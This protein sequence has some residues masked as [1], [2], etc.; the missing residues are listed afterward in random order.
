M[1]SFLGYSQ[2]QLPDTLEVCPSASTFN[3]EMNFNSSQSN[4]LTA[5]S[6]ATFTDLSLA[7]DAFSPLIN[8]GFNFNFYGTNYSSCVIS[9]NNFISFNSLNANTASVFTTSVALGTSSPF[10][11][12]NSI[13]APFQD[14]NPQNS[15]N[16]E[17]TTIGTAP[18]R[19][20]VAR[21]YDI[22]MYDCPDL[23]FCSAIIFYESTNIIETHL[24]NKP[25]CED[26]QNGLAIHGLLNSNGTASEVVYDSD[27]M[28]DR[29]F[30][31]LW[32][33]TLEG[34]RFTPSGTNN[35]NVSSINFL[36]IVS[37]ATSQYED[38]L[39]NTYPLQQNTTINNV[40]G[41]T[42]L[43]ASSSVC[44][45]SLRDTT[46]IIDL[47][48]DILIDGNLVNTAA[49][50][51]DEDAIL[52]V[53]NASNFDSFLWSTGET[54]SS[55]TINSTGTYSVTSTKDGCPLS[56]QVTIINHPTYSIDLGI[57]SVICESQT[58]TLNGTTSNT[59][60][61]LWDNGSTNSTRTV[62]TTGDY[63]L[64]GIS[65]QGCEDSDTISITVLPNPEIDLGDDI[66]VCQGVTI[67]IGD[68]I[69]GGNYTWNTGSTSPYIEI[70]SSG[71]YILT[72]RIGN[73]TDIDTIEVNY[74][75][76]PTINL[77]SVAYFCEGDSVT[78]NAFHSPLA[79]YLW[80]DGSNG[81][82]YTSSETELVWVEVT[83]ND[84]SFRDSI[85]IVENEI[86][87][88]DLGADTILCEDNTLDLTVPLTGGIYLWNTTEI[89]Q[90]INVFTTGIY[91]V[92]YTINNCTYRDSIEVT[93]NESPTINLG[94]D[95]I[96]CLGDSVEFNAFY[97]SNSTYLWHDGSTQSTY[98]ST[99]TEEIWVKVFLEN[100]SYTDTIN[101]TFLNL[102]QPN[103]G[104]DS[105][106]CEGEILTLENNTTGASYLWSTGQTSNSIDV[107]T[108][109]IYWLRT[110]I[111][112]CIEVDTIE[113]TFEESPIIN[114][115]PNTSGCQGDSLVLNA[116]Y[117]TLSTYLWQDG[118]TNSSYT[119]HSS[120]LIWVEVTLGNCSFRDTIIYTIN[121]YPII[122]LGSDF[123]GCEGDLVSLNI[124]ENNATYLWST[125]DTTQQISPTSS[126]LY[127]GQV[128]KNNCTSIDS[129]Q[130][131][132]NEVPIVN[133]GNPVHIC[134]G[135]SITF[136]AFYNS[137][138]TYLWHDG[139]TSS[140]YTTSNSETIWV[141]IN[142][143]NCSFTD[144]VSVTSFE[145]PVLD[146]GLDQIECVG[147]TVILSVTENNADYNWSSGDTT[148]TIQVTQTGIYTVE[149]SKNGCSISD[150]V[151]VT[152]NPIPQINLGSNTSL[153]QGDS[154]TFN[155]YYNANATYLWH[156]GS[157]NSSYTSFNSELIFVTVFLDNCSFTDTVANTVFEYPII[158]LGNDIEV[159]EDIPVFLEV[160]E[161]GARYLWNTGDTTQSIQ[162]MSSGEYRVEVEKNN[163]VSFDTINVLLKDIPEINLGGD[164]AI[165]ETESITFDAFYSSN[166]TYLWHDGSTGSTYTGTQTE[167]IEV[168]L[169]LN[170][171]T[172]NESL[173]L[174]VNP[175][176]E[177]SLDQIYEICEGD[178]IE[179]NGFYSNSA[180]Y[181]W[182]T[183]STNSSE[184]FTQEGNYSITV[185]D[186]NCEFSADFKV[187][188]HENPD[189]NLNDIGICQGESVAVNAYDESLI[190]YQ[191]STGETGPAIEISEEKWYWV[192]LQNV[193]CTIRDSFYL[194][195]QNAPQFYLPSDTFM[196]ET[197]Q[198]YLSVEAEDA[199]ILWSTGATTKNILI[200]ELG[201]YTVEVT[202]ACGVR[203]DTVKI[204]P[205]DC[206]CPIYVPN[207]I[208]S[209]SNSESGTFKI[210]SDCGDF[211]IFDLSIYNRWGKLIFQSDDPNNT[212]R[213]GP[214][215]GLN[216]D[217]YIY[218]LRYG[219]DQKIQNEKMGE[220]ILL[221]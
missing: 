109:G 100:C 83:L 24:I 178:S 33:T 208:N 215:S 126:G 10:D 98:I 214:D 47:E 194:T 128:T 119:S 168:E 212:W 112:Q 43:I 93:F 60:S 188:V 12:R 99:Q 123:V 61:Y 31:N 114:L 192:D 132:F 87:E 52:T 129:I 42:R 4:I 8:I 14:I 51:E 202:N 195:V 70:N 32:T 122:N 28:V 196:C 157:T 66:N 221:H 199:Q 210:V 97:N 113:V 121:P 207:A 22:P 73:C 170:G 38:N 107:T 152:F 71:T 197:E 9:S 220:I 34:T 217:V 130:V 111:G 158:N 27:Q 80:K 166:T 18:N 90:T 133:L 150:T 179:I 203:N 216:Q 79:S 68:S 35:Y 156:N 76:L 64:H 180:T 184:T 82:T 1:F 193:N 139:S 191:W 137:A 135:D 50:C 65:N 45:S 63:V 89:T 120:E 19:A 94:N 174:T 211:G 108:S 165:C 167:F 125:G 117:N 176:P 81:S 181:L 198:L 88:F 53:L 186:K 147:D 26:W 155:A 144:T 11:L 219:F 29:D 84:C 37:L 78:I 56:S 151:N 118:S 172:F 23:T 85:E 44:S 161:N 15:G 159:C 16:I 86:P 105:I 74:S 162:A 163:C 154:I 3:I 149:V 36:P 204:F 91:Y 131:T 213:P 7:D 17:Y 59:A 30:G 143:A 185:T 175:I 205:E 104:N 183:L 21:W 160:T 2:F 48:T 55:I 92:D 46:Y 116:T 146:L 96:S 189:T 169:T 75:N 67:T 164:T 190:G 138:S 134:E 171:C 41:L 136:N 62:S 72:A 49:I 142:L 110:S 57:D 201:I 206:S 69:N 54:T 182:S 101:S 200:E 25:T 13:L 177:I 218:K 115:G 140:T 102:P 173:L 6:N 148:Q 39:G 103:L 153:C 58:I 209:N 124:S 95:T 40:P 127:I 187:V 106:L 5:I 145:Y 20:F 141:E 77:D